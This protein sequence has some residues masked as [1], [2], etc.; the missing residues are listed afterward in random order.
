[1]AATG[2]F[3]AKTR[4]KAQVTATGMINC[5]PPC[6]PPIRRFQINVSVVG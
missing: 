3:V 6:P 5:N 4:G 1:M 2:T